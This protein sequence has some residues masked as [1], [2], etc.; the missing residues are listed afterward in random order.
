METFWRAAIDPRAK[1]AAHQLSQFLPI[2]QQ[3]L[4]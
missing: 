1:R 2:Q 4:R 3:H